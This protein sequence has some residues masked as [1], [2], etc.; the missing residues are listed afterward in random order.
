MDVLA[1]GWWLSRRRVRDI[2]LISSL[3][4]LAMLIILNFGGTGTLDPFGK[5][6]GSDF[7]A[8]WE[9]G[10]I[11]N[12]GDAAR[13]WDQQLLNDSI[14]AAH[15]SGYGTAWIYP[16]VFL[17]VVSPL[18]ALPYLAATFLWQLVSLFAIAL[19]L[20]AILKSNRDTCIALASPLTPLVLANGQNS[21][22]TAALLGAC[23]LMLDRKPTLAGGLFGGLIYK[24]QLG[25]VLAP[26]LL[27]GGHWRAFFGGAIAA[28]GL[29]AASVLLWG[30][31]SWTAWLGSL[32]YGRTY[33][34]LGSVGFHKSVSLFSM[35]RAWGAGVEFSYVVQAIGTVGAIILLWMGRNAPTAVKAACACAAVALST[36]YL[37]DYDLAVI[38]VGS[39]F[40]YVEAR[41]T[42]FLPFEKTA[43]AFVWAAPLYVRPVAEYTLIPLGQLAILMVAWL[44]WRRAS[45]HRHATVDVQGL[46]GDISGLTA[47]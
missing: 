4:G 36:P 40:L 39:A 28:I 8:F 11:A 38:G 35:V 10:R 24:P 44:A 26:L 20:K 23:L 13:A 21:F 41:R 18:A 17:F 27:F 25:I 22:V 33:M 30:V 34:E 3:I 14:R 2:A 29:I 42:A 6:V 31:D 15:H 43:L 19:T 37:L 16:P 46:P 47:R 1:N 12:L 45:E 7:A 5:P 32:H 9:A